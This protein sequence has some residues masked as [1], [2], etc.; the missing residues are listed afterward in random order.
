ML[1][2]NGREEVVENRVPPAPTIRN[3]KKRNLQIDSKKDKQTVRR[4]RIIQLHR[5]ALYPGV[6]I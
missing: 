4:E 1:G 2:R 5:N 3:K 6:I